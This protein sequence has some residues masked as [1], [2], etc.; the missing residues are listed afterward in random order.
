VFLNLLPYYTI[1]DRTLKNLPQTIWGG[2]APIDEMR[3]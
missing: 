1:Y 3:R 2:T